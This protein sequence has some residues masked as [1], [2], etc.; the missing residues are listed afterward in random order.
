MIATLEG[1]IEILRGIVKISVH[2]VLCT[3]PDWSGVASSTICFVD[4]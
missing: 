1:C 2:T 4:F 3:F